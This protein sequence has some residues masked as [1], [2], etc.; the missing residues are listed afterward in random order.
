M[1][2]TCND[3][4]VEEPLPRTREALIQWAKARRLRS[5]TAPKLANV[6]VRAF[7]H[8][9]GVSEEI[10]KLALVQAYEESLQHSPGPATE[11]ELVK[12]TEW[13]AYRARMLIS[14]NPV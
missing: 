13:V 6:M 8:E 9:M 12:V 4:R 7:A 11:D 3:T 10:A 5:V 1:S 14:W 2:S